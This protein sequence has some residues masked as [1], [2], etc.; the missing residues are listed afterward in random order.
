[1][2]SILLIFKRTSNN[3]STNLLNYNVNIIVMPLYG[4]NFVLENQPL[5]LLIKTSL[6]NLPAI[7]FDRIMYASLSIPAKPLP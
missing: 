6:T 1:M 2:I 4:S 3:E 5:V 7:L